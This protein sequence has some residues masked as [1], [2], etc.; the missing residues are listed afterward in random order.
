MASHFEQELASYDTAFQ[1]GLDAARALEQHPGTMGARFED[2]VRLTI[3]KL[4]P[5]TH[6][7]RAALGVRR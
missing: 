7:V 6:G 2:S 4:I 5:A 1:H 3:Q